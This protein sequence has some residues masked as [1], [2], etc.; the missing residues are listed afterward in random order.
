MSTTISVIVYSLLAVK[1]HTVFGGAESSIKGLRDKTTTTVSSFLMTER[2][3]LRFPVS[4]PLRSI[5][6]TILVL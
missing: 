6:K 2:V 3:L 4:L 1:F 5:Q